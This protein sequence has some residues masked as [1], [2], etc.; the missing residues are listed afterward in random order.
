MHENKD[1]KKFEY[2][3]FLHS[4]LQNVMFWLEEI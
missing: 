2:E 1:Q 3:R 4:T